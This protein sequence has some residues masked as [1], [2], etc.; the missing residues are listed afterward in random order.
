MRAASRVALLVAAAVALAVPR[1]AS[2]HEAG[3]KIAGS[4]PVSNV[5]GRATMAVTVQNV[6]SDSVGNLTPAHRLVTG[7]ATFFTCRPHRVRCAAP[8]EQEARIRK[9]RFTATACST[10][11]WKSPESWPTRFPAHGHRELQPGGG[12]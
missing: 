8:A 1:A 10:C 7:N 2:A 4:C 9:G 5:A 11:R 12:R 3:G 6:W